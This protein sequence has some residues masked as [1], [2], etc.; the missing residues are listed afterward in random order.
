[1]T[2]A[3]AAN[4]AKQLRNVGQ[5]DEQIK[6]HFEKLGYHGPIGDD[7]PKTSAP[8]QEAPATETAP[9]KQATPALDPQRKQLIEMMLAQGV[10]LSGDLL[11]DA[12]THGLVDVPEAGSAPEGAPVGAVAPTTPPPA[13]PTPAE[14]AKPDP[15][16]DFSDEAL[17][18]ND[19]SQCAGWGEHDAADNALPDVETGDDMTARGAVEAGFIGLGEEEEFNDRI[20]IYND[21]F[22]LR[23]PEGTPKATSRQLTKGPN[24]GK[25][26]WER[27]FKTVAGRIV[28][29]RMQEFDTHSSV[30]VTVDAGG[31]LYDVML[32]WG[33]SAGDAFLKQLPNVDFSQP[34]VL[35][36]F[37]GDNDRTAL[38]VK[39]NGK[40]V[41]WAFTKDNPNGM[42]EPK[43]VDDIDDKGRPVKKWDWRAQQAFLWKLGN[44]YFARLSSKG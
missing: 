7:A 36:V 11:T 3:Q 1:M 14:T 41:G 8:K 10:E 34:V 20:T 21:K 31:H 32:S 2:E 39:Q 17:N 25:T 13:Q 33:S 43:V 9:T 37:K 19:G 40:S 6:A 18:D 12:Q 22:V 29:G 16:N 26:V 23:V 27:S 5:S 4:I 24:E 42:P 35:N 38:V 44:D 28:A 15:A 30:V